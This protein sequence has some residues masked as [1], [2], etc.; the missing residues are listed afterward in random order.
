MKKVLPL[1]SFAFL[2]CISCS[3]MVL[4]DVS[5]ENDNRLKSNEL[6]LAE[7]LFNLDPIVDGDLSYTAINLNG[8]QI[9]LDYDLISRILKD[10]NIYKDAFGTKSPPSTWHSCQLS[11]NSSCGYGC[12]YEGFYYNEWGHNSNWVYHDTYFIIRLNWD[13]PGPAPLGTYMVVY[14]FFYCSQDCCTQTESVYQA[15]IPQ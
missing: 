5:P 9:L 3:N 8:K 15:A 4:S 1:I 6:Y 7:K 14:Y 13:P 12:V 2:I 11:Q 10:E